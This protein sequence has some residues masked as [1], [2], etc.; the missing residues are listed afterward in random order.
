MDIGEIS[1]ILEANKNKNFVDRI[2]NRDKYPTLDL[3]EGQTAS[4]LMSWGQ[5]GDKYRVFPTVI[6]ENN[7]L[8]RYSPDEAWSKASESSEFIDFSS[9]EEADWFSKNYK[10]YWDMQDQI[11]RMNKSMEIP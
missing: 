9:P 2:L 7:R 5:I 11:D 10:K 4:H 3:G 8:N 6:Y 1:Q